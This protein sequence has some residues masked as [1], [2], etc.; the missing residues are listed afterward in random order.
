MHLCFGA[1]WCKSD[2]GT[3]ELLPCQSF[4][5]QCSCSKNRL[6]MS[7][8]LREFSH[9]KH[10]WATHPSETELILSYLVKHISTPFYLMH[11]EKKC[12]MSLC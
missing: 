5:K 4:S 9:S 2:V 3:L 10:R 6:K 11:L 7:R 8:F 12:L 1:A